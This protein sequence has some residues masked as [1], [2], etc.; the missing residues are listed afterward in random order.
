[1]YDKSFN[2]GSREINLIL[3]KFEN[4]AAYNVQTCM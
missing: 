1:M 3:L 4:L 2:L